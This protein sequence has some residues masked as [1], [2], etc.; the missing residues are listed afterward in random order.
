MITR[1]QAALLTALAVL[2]VLA[3][4]YAA[5]GRAARRAVV[6]KTQKRQIEAAEDRH[7]VEEDVGRMPDDVVAERLRTDWTKD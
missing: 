7:D 3:G 5:G 2:L 4:A 6:A 1:L